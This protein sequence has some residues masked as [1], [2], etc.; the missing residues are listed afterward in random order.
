MKTGLAMS[1]TNERSL[2]YETQHDSWF[3]TCFYQ[4]YLQAHSTS[5]CVV[6]ADQFRRQF[7]TGQ[8]R[9]LHGTCIKFQ[10][11]QINSGKIASMPLKLPRRLRNI[12]ITWNNY[13][14]INNR[15][16]AM[17]NMCILHELIRIYGQTSVNGSQSKL[18]DNKFHGANKGA[19]CFLSAAVGP[20]IG[21]IKLPMRADSVIS[22][23]QTWP[24]QSLCC[25]TGPGCCLGK[26]DSDHYRYRERFQNFCFI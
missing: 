18:P 24:L 4:L 3:P 6:I 25:A 8:T 10:M 5:T 21:P 20:N 12:Y 26:H 1:S 13:H 9:N 2:Y 23:Y 16:G 11:K 17:Q 15:D 22:Y 14:L 7:R 19:T